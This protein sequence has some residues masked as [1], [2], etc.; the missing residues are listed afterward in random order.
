MAPPT[1]TELHVATVAVRSQEGKFFADEFV[2]PV[3]SCG[4]AAAQEAAVEAD[5]AAALARALQTPPGLQRR[6]MNGGGWQ[7]AGRGRGLQQQ[8]QVQQQHRGAALS[9][10]AAATAARPVVQGMQ[11][12]AAPSST[13]SAV[14][15]AAGAAD[16]GVASPADNSPVVVPAAGRKMDMADD[17]TA[18]TSWWGP[19][20]GRAPSGT[21]ASSQAAR[22]RDQD[23]QRNGGVEGEK[24]G[25]GQGGIKPAWQFRWPW[26]ARPQ[27]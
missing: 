10:T 3:M 21:S 12:Q 17:M 16:H 18:S 2:G 14:A 25:A 22:H 4:T 1:P 5:V 19:S 27:A 20:W 7:E 6:R 24:A 13:E 23:D 26:D 15:K 8:Q 9:Q 11:L